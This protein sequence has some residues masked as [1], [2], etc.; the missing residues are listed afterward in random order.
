MRGRSLIVLA[1]ALVLSACGGEEHSDLRQFVKESDKLPVGRIP[2]LPEV[3]PYE[4]F[5]YN[6][7]D[8][9]DPFKPRK[10]EPPKSAAKGGLQPDFNRPREALEAFPLENLKMVGTLQQKQQVFAL[11]KA[12]D[13]SLYRV[14]S[15]NYLGQNF[16]RIVGI[17]ETDIQLKEIVQDSGGN[18][19]EKDQ[20]LLLQEQ[21]AKK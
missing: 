21:E 3:K 20:A 18:W 5:A 13:S 4:P 9:T 10:I 8:L 7:Y 14:T 11:V 12:P 6:A 1:C 17:T 2:P 15:G 19:E 16:G